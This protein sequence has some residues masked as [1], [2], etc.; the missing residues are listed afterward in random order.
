MHKHI[1]RHTAHS[2]SIATHC[3]WLLY[4]RVALNMASENIPVGYTSGLILQVTLIWPQL[5]LRFLN[6][7]AGH[8]HF[9]LALFFMPSGKRTGVSIAS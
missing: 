1:L 4:H 2:H 7:T 9:I 6:V 5:P 8:S 3:P